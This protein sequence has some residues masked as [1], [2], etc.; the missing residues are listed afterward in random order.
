MFG[1]W[2]SHLAILRVLRNRSRWIGTPIRHSAHPPS[3]KLG[4]PRRRNITIPISR[5][6]GFGRES[7]KCWRFCR[8]YSIAVFGNC[9]KWSVEAHNRPPFLLSRSPTGSEARAALASKYVKT[10]GRPRQKCPGNRIIH[11]FCVI[12]RPDYCVVPVSRVLKSH[13]PHFI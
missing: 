1:R 8:N 5:G 12:F 13:R 9:V 7:R 10:D 6:A 2:I 11:R 4:R 3:R